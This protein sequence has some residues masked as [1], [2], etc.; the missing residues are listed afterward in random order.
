MF[1]FFVFFLISWTEKLEEEEKSH[2]STFNQLKEGNSFFILFLFHRLFFAELNTTKATHSEEMNSLR[3]RMDN[4][5]EVINKRFTQ[6]VEKE[7][8]LKGIFYKI[9]F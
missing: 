4:L 8:S 3:S 2:Q 1:H 7:D 5:T 9:C 6:N